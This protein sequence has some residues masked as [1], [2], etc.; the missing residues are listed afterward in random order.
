MSLQEDVYVLKKE[1]ALLERKLEVEVMNSNRLRR[2][3]DDLKATIRGLAQNIDHIQ[4]EH[5]KEVR[6]TYRRLYSDLCR[7]V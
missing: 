6:N 3:V 2:Q 7:E 1:K 4:S 5:S